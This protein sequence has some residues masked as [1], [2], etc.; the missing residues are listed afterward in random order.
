[1]VTIKLSSNDLTFHI[2]A[3]SLMAAKIHRNAQQNKFFRKE[4]RSLLNEFYKNVLLLAR[5]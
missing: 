1:M 3:L 5:N 2:F 4:G